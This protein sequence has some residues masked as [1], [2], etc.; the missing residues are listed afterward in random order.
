MPLKTAAI[1]KKYPA[2]EFVCADK[3]FSSVLM[4]K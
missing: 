4:V 3:A 2:T 1:Y